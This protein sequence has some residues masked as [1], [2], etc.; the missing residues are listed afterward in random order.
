MLIENAVVRAPYIVEPTSAGW[1]V[2]RVN[3][4]WR[5]G[6]D[7]IL[8]R[9]QEVAIAY[10]DAAAALEKYLGSLDRGEDCAELFEAWRRCDDRYEMLAIEQS[11]APTLVTSDGRAIATAPSA[12]RH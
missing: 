4:D 3:A 11:D 7:A 12:T 10:A 8:H 1:R 6:V 2:T 9:R 5:D